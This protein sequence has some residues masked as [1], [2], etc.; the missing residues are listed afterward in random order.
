M[1]A[2]IKQ[3]FILLLK[4]KKFWLTPIIIALIVVAFL[5]IAAQLSPVP[6]FLYPLI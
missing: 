2:A 4:S 6:I 5:I 3:L 1:L